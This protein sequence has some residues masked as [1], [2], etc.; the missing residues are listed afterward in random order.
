VGV[1]PDSGVVFGM[2]EVFGLAGAEVAGCVL[3]VEG[4]EL[5]PVHAVRIAE[6]V[7]TAPASVRPLR[8]DLS[9]SNILPPRFVVMSII[10]SH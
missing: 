1:V 8:C 6:P 2:G 5:P 10:L 3:S 4:I 7:R 9:V